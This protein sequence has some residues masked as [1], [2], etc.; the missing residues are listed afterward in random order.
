MKISILV[1]VALCATRLLRNQSAAQRHWILAVAIVCAGVLPMLELL[2][3]A[4]PLSIGSPSF[5]ELTLPSHPAAAT[6]RTS[7]F[8]ADRITRQAGAP[9][10]GS[11]RDAVRGWS[12]RSI[13]ALMWIAGVAM[14][15]LVLVLGLIRL[16]WLRSRARPVT[17]AN[18]TTL[19]EQ[20]A[21]EYGLRHPVRVLQSD[22]SSLLAT[23]GVVSPTIMIPGGAER[24]PD[25]LV[26]MVLSHELAHIRRGDWIVQISA[27]LVRSMYWFNPL[28]WL[29]CRRLRLESEHA[30]DD[31]VLRSGVDSSAYASHL[32]GLARAFNH[33]HPLFPAPAM[34]RSSSL[35]KR[36]TAMLNDRQNRSPMSPFA[37]VATVMALA[38]IAGTIAAAQVFATFSGSLVDPQGA[39]LPGVRV[40]LSNAE[41]QIKYDA[42]TNRR[43][44]FEIVG[45]PPGDYVFEVQ[46][47]GFKPYRAALTMT[48]DN[49][50]RAITLEIGSVAEEIVIAGDGDSSSRAVQTASPRPNPPCPST[51]ATADVP[52]GGN[53]RPPNK[54]R[55]VRPQYPASVRGTGAD[56]TIVLD[57]LIGTDGFLKDV[58]VRE[59]ANREFANALLAAVNQWQYDSTLLN[60]VPIEVAVTITGRFV[61]GR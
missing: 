11:A 8:S 19:S 41:R 58:R 10:V 16:A 35:H 31:A 21:R 24:W 14:G 32:L 36:V 59:P 4:W 22:D 1:L 28:V 55:D 2:V 39:A 61:H 53:I 47:P 30:C 52:I 42:Q 25:D 6:E 29:A 37:R 17:L 34:A 13:L 7:T 18:W 23:W 45:L 46:V 54:I 56:A 33:R 51:A 5:A 26:G 57:A 15:L 44:E 27:E 43:G 38:V 40:T 48:G 12:T 9:V 49:A 20:I 3:P 50:R 60:C